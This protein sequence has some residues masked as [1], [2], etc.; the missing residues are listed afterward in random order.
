VRT[1]FVV[2]STTFQ[3]VLREEA[4]LNEYVGFE[5]QE[6][7][8]V[9]SLAGSLY[10]Q[11]RITEARALFEGLIA[12]DPQLYLG[13]SGLGAID[14]IEERLDSALANLTRAAELTPGDPSVHSNLGEVLLRKARFPEASRC[15][16][17]ALELDPKQA[18]PGANR[19]RAIIEALK[20]ATKDCTKAV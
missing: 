20:V 1:D 18:D 2:P 4:G 12:L 19:A 11:G 7:C 3:K 14:L 9:A 6:L 8:A 17:I 5:R 16:Q 10:G 13:Y 15:F